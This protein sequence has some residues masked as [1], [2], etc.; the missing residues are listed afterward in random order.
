MGAVLSIPC[1]EM[2]YLVGLDIQSNVE[3]MSVY[4]YVLL[5]PGKNVSDPALLF[6]ALFLMLVASKPQRPPLL[7][8]Y[9]H[10]GFSHRH[11]ELRF[12]CLHTKCLCV[13]DME[14]VWRSQNNWGGVLFYSTMWIL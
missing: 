13:C 10:D 6:S 4:P 3:C 12:S 2:F 1:C 5:D 7:C 14:P 11:G 8:S 9:R